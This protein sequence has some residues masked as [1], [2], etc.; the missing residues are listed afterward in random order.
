MAT[1]NWVIAAGAMVGGIYA[2][3]RW[4]E[5]FWLDIRTVEIPIR[6]LDPAF[7][8][9]RIA[10]LSDIHWNPRMSLEWI[11]DIVARA[12]ALDADVIALG[13][14]VVLSRTKWTA[15]GIRVLGTLRA[16]DGVRA[17]LGNHDYGRSGGNGWRLRRALADSGIVELWNDAVPIE[18]NGA[19]LWLGGVG[20]LWRDAC[21]IA[22]AFRGIPADEPRVLLCHNPDGILQSHGTRVDLMISGHTH[23]G[24][25]RIPFLG[26]IVTRTET[27]RKLG[28]GLAYWGDTAV[29]TGRGIGFGR[30]QIRFLSRPEMP[31]IVLRSR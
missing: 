5:P 12:N 4:V 6:G 24:Q 1:S 14:D 31:V 2:Y 17:V 18:R 11:E 23:G 29:Y 9:Y 25:V 8:G 22:G 28:D 13:G 3:A 27:G 21:D 7:D 30:T 20:D 19:R 26:A 10:W 15:D 16:P